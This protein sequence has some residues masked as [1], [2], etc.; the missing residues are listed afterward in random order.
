M[1][2]KLITVIVPVYNVEQY[3]NRCIDSIINQSYKNLEIILVDDGSNDNSGLICDD[4]ANND[5]R[6]KVIHKINGGLSDARN[7]GL[8]VM[9]GDYIMFVD[10]D[11]FID[12]DMVQILFNDLIKNKSDISICTFNSIIN[13]E[14]RPFLFE[15]KY[16]VVSGVDKFYYLY[17]EYSGI[18]VSSCMK[19]FSAKLFKNV[20]FEVG[21]IHED[22]III[23][24][25]LKSAKSISYVLEPLYNYEMRDGSITKKFDFRKI[26]LLPYIDLRIDYFKSIN[27]NTLVEKTVYKKLSILL[28][29]LI[30]YYRYDDSHLDDNDFV[31]VK[32]NIK[33]LSKS[34]LK[35]KSL[36]FKE[37]INSFFAYLVSPKMYYALKCI[38]RR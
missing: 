14:K 28:T 34:C 36:S 20:F 29:L 9:S 18:T 21:K 31:K 6:I 26:D 30:D 7:A 11:D 22:E 19:L 4:Y 5:N 27:C 25:L 10:S 32:S 1:N 8:K 24:D 23:L 33:S 38:I 16:F 35:Y 13:N 15:K 17:N 37:H 12:L 3:L 2:N